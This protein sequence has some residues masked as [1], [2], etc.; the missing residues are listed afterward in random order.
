MLGISKLICK[1]TAS[2][3]RQQQSIVNQLRYFYFTQKKFE[4]LNLNKKLI[5]SLRDCNYQYLTPCQEISLPVVIE[6]NNAAILAETGSG[7]TLVYTTPIVNNFYN[8]A[9]KQ[10]KTRRGAIILTPNKELCSQVYAL[11]RSLEPTYAMRVTR[12]GQLTSI[13]DD[14]NNRSPDIFLHQN[15]VSALNW[16][17]F[18]VVIS[19]PT[20]LANELAIKSSQE[21][22]EIKPKT[23][24]IDEMD[25]LLGDVNIAKATQ[26]ILKMLKGD[27]KGVQSEDP[28]QYILAGASFPRKLANN[29]SD[30]VLKTWFGNLAILETRKLH[31]LS[32]SLSHE[33]I[34]LSSEETLETRLEMLSYLLAKKGTKKNIVFCNGGEF[35]DPITKFL[36]EKKFTVFPLHAKM[37]SEDR[38]ASI[39]QFR[40]EEQ[41]ILVT[42]DLASRGIDILDV[43]MIVQFDFAKDA[44]TLL[45]RL[46]R[47]ARVGQ[48]GLAVSFVQPTDEFLAGEFLRVQETSG[49]LSEIF[50]RKRS[51][52]KRHKVPEDV[53]VKES[54]EQ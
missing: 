34:R 49:N 41:G 8:N 27:R 4:D 36:E 23:L 37:R 12:L 33:M 54:Q 32:D 3:F 53:I 30:Q 31:K 40:K 46:G 1:Q 7:K 48:K 18:D 25:L 28:L 11:I 2:H 10:G 29:A 16:N 44:T 15:I 47:V 17:H 24:V 21:L 50:S 52:R 5:K 35:I 6:G 26:K 14:A 51:L 22:S 43:E 19:T 45:H 20:Q 39:A 9:D 42:T 13:V 38:I